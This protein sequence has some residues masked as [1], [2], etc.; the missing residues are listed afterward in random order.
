MMRAA[1]GAAVGQRHEQQREAHARASETIAK[2][3]QRGPASQHHW[4]TQT[5]REETG[6]DLK[7]RHGA[8][9]QTAHQAELPIAEPE[10]SLPD[11]QHH[12]DEIGVAVMQ[13]MC[14]AGNA[15]GAAL[16][17]SRPRPFD[18]LTARNCHDR[19]TYPCLRSTKAELMNDNTGSPRWLVPV[20]RAVM[21]PHSG[22]LADGRSSTTSVA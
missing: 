14:P 10:F 11:R 4:C 18:R 8:G 12:N 2:P 3:R 20:L 16:L 15:S 13:R 1:A 9:E 22:R 21:I 7:R 6:R 5:L 19:F 17:T